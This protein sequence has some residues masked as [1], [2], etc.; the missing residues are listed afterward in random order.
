MNNNFDMFEVYD[1]FCIN[2]DKG[3]SYQKHFTNDNEL[4]DFIS[5]VKSIGNLTDMYVCST[6]ISKG[7]L[8]VM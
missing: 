6:I 5:D 7:F 2:T 8:K 3:I 4:T 1:V